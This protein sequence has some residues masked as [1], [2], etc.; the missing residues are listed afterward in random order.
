[1]AENFLQ[2]ST[3]LNSSVRAVAPWSGST[4]TY[5]TGNKALST[6]TE[7]SS[8]RPQRPLSS[9]SV[10]KDAWRPVKYA[11]M[12][13]H[14]HQSH[15]S[16]IPPTSP[17]CWP[18]P[19]PHTTHTHQLTRTSA[20]GSKHSLKQM[21]EKKTPSFTDSGN[22][23]HHRTRQR[24]F[25]LLQ[26]FKKK[27]VRTQ[28]LHVSTIFTVQYS[29]SW[30]SPLSDAVRKP[31]QSEHFAAFEPERVWTGGSNPGLSTVH[32]SSFLHLS[33]AHVGL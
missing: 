10:V 20:G 5:P 31:I 27:C 14:R 18:P 23:L 29:S 8:P 11:S 33:L 7:A 25:S 19:N 21:G 22:A 1:M 4:L 30:L 26:I 6:G 13:H 2:R 12:H 15:C 16:H 17:P 32:I 24:L 9:L 3:N 28:L